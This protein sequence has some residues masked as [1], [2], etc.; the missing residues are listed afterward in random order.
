[1]RSYNN[2]HVSHYSLF[3]SVLFSELSDSDDK[4]EPC[5]AMDDELPVDREPELELEKTNSGRLVSN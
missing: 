3:L 5:Q 4:K 1:M 2:L